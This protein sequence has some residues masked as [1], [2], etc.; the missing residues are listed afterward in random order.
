MSSTDAL[1]AHV[2]AF[3]ER[4]G[5]DPMLIQG[6]GGNVSWK[7][8]DTLWIKASGAWLA[9]A[10]S[11]DLFVP[12]DLTGVRRCIAEGRETYGE[13]RLGGSSLRPSIETALHALMPQTLVAHLHAIDAIA[14][15]VRIDGR[16]GVAER[17][18]G[19]RWM[20]VPYC[21]PGAELASRIAQQLAEC[22]TAPDV[23]I[24]ANHGIVFCAD[25]TAAIE[26]LYFETLR[27]LR[28]DPRVVPSPSAAGLPS[29][30]GHRPVE[31]TATMSLAID[32]VSLTLAKEHWVLYPDHAVFL[33]PQARIYPDLATAGSAIEVTNAE[34]RARFP[35]AIVEGQGVWIDANAS[36]V[37][38]AM[39]DCYADVCLR[40]RTS[41]S[42]SSLSD[43]SVF[44]L[45]DWEAE[46]YRKSL[47]Q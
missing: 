27:R 11:Q 8:G 20:W 46:K 5:S 21:K 14:W 37:V 38:D 29:L 18:D 4:V 2:E 36:G 1:R 43:D 16:E 30:E 10:R 22:D 6:A 26:R 28:L 25:D 33:G 15:A 45:L 44:A 40:L 24:L 7:E 35:C 3:S 23:L 34:Q 12:V 32:A 39:L 9:H 47:S 42:A 41:A 19:L 17:L 31:R 13:H